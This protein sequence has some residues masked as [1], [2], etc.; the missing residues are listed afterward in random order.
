VLAGIPLE[1]GRVLDKEY[2][3]HT[4]IKISQLYLEDEES[5]QAEMY[6]NRASVDV[7]Q[8]KDPMIQL[9]FKSCFA[10]ILDHKRKFIEAA[11]KYHE[12]SQVVGEQERVEALKMAITCAIL[13]K[14]GPQRQRML[15][16]LY[17]DERSSKLEIFHTLEKMYLERVI[18]KQEVDVFVERLLAHQMA[19]GGD[20][21]KVHERAVIEHNLLAASKIYTNISFDEL[22]SLLEIPPERAEKIAAKMIVEDRLRGTI[23]QTKR[24]IHF[25]TGSNTHNVWDSHIESLCGLTNTTVEVI[26]QRYPQFVK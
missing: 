2:K 10:R 5:V 21:L 19:D 14:A 15:A 8:V 23:D 16:S 26:G 22:G 24:I 12:L 13:A 20:G 1:G 6:I 7:T 9:R 11:G 3:V 17:K 18:R 25:A 4:Y